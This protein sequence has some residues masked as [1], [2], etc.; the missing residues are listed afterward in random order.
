MTKIGSVG[1]VLLLR[2]AQICHDVH[3]LHEVVHHVSVPHKLL[4]GLPVDDLCLRNATVSATNIR[5]F[6]KIRTRHRKSF[7]GGCVSP[8]SFVG[9]AL[10]VS[11]WSSF[12]PGT[13][14]TI[15]LCS[16]I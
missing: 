12:Q 16:V 5:R 11:G 3:R 4:C 15:C 7:Y 10:C 8:T 9:L 14:A 6:P 1:M 13:W 2:G